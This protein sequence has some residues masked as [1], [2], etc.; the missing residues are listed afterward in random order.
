M[1]AIKRLIEYISS[2]AGVEWVKMEDICDDFKKKN[3]PIEGALLPVAPGAIARNPGK[4][5]FRSKLEEVGN[6]SSLSLKTSNSK[7]LD[8]QSYKKREE[9]GRHHGGRRPTA[10]IWVAVVRR[11]SQ[12]LL[13][14]RI[15]KAKAISTPFL[16]VSCPH[17]CAAS[18]PIG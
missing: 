5:G 6:I 9:P 11:P 8:L 10:C 4:Q 1:V 2:K 18:A 16:K 15:H 14:Q 12:G 17:C 3:K 7:G 13:P